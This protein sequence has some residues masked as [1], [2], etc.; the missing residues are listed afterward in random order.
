MAKS[1]EWLARTE[2][3]HPWIATEKR[4]FGTGDYT[5]EGEDIA[6]K[7]KEYEDLRDRCDG[8]QGKVQA[9][10]RDGLLALTAAISWPLAMGIVAL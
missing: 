7:R 4:H 6:A 5:F 9:S 1:K 10:V 3:E 2:S 8:F